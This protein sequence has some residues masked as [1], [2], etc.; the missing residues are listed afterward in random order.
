MS[1]KLFNEDVE[2]TCLWCIYG[3]KSEYTSEVFCKKYGVVTGGEVCRKYKYDPLKR[4][5]DT[6]K[7]DT[8]YDPENF[9]L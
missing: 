4:T 1:V 9:I 2:K 3:K 7:I 5:P 6:P 8:E